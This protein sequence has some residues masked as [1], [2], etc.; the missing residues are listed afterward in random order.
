[1][2]PD[3][4]HM[5]VPIYNNPVVYSSCP[6]LLD[7]RPYAV[8]NLAKQISM[9][10]NVNPS[11]ITGIDIIWETYVLLELSAFMTSI[12]GQWKRKPFDNYFFFLRDHLPFEISKESSVA[13]YITPTGHLIGSICAVFTW[14]PFTSIY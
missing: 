1:M 14:S 9:T 10:W 4:Q 5:I 3:F 13:L 11:R 8:L 7:I 2:D 12:E 6:P